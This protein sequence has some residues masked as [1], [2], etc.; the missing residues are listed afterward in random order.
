MNINTL[1]NDKKD[2]FAPHVFLPSH[3]P[4]HPSLRE[5]R[6][7]EERHTVVKQITAPMTPNNQLRT[8]AFQRT[9]GVYSLTRILLARRMS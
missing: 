1:E 7:E 6:I 2:F 9:K 5:A 4:A 3:L 8:A